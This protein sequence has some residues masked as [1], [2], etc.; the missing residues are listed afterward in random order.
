MTTKPPPRCVGIRAANDECS[1]DRGPAYHRFPH[2][3]A[4]LQV[5]AYA[6]DIVGEFTCTDGATG[7]KSLYHFT[8]TER[9]I[10][11][12]CMQLHVRPPVSVMRCLVLRTA[13]AAPSSCTACRHC[14]AV[15][16]CRRRNGMGGQAGSH[17]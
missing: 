15:A 11:C 2:C 5:T 8:T 10:S 17:S 3:P 13:A 9:F 16:R 1:I 12:A 14:R 6:D 4:R 7:D